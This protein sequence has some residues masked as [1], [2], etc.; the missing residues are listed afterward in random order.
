VASQAAMMQARQAQQA[1]VGSQQVMY[2]SNQQQSF[3]PAQ[4]Q[5]FQVSLEERL[6]EEILCKFLMLNFCSLY[7]YFFSLFD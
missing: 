3:Q 7:L 4:A 6:S 2:H 1:G 5:A